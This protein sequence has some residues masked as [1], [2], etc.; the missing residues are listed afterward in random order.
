M[1]SVACRPA[2]ADS[3]DCTHAVYHKYSNATSVRATLLYNL[4]VRFASL[5]ASTFWFSSKRCMGSS[6]RFNKWR[7]LPVVQTA[8]TQAVR[9]DCRERG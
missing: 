7:L 9:R 3:I 1:I 8:R 5:E 6:M 2:L 4:T